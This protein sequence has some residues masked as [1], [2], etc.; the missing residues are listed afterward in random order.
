MRTIR[1]NTTELVFDDAPLPQ[2]RRR[3]LGALSV[4]WR[5]FAAA[6][7]LAFLAAQAAG[8]DVSIS[9]T[10]PPGSDGLQDLLN[11]TSYGGAITCAGTAIYGFAKMGLSHQ[12]QSYSGA[13]HGKAVALLAMVGAL[14]LGLTPTIVNGLTAIH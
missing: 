11:W 14:G 8:A 5:S 1:R 10:A 4:A 9:P 6:V 12:N 7:T 3:R 13:N 2:T